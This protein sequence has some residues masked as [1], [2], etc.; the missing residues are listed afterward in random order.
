LSAV[1]RVIDR[2]TPIRELSIP[3]R[4]DEIGIDGGEPS[5]RRSSQVHRPG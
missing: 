1:K 5:S 4:S 3:D 2:T